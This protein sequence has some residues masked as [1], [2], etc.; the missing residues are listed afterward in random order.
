MHLATR[1]LRFFFD[2]GS[3]V[4]LWQRSEEAGAHGPYAVDHEALPLTRNTKAALTALVA[5][6]DLSIDWEDAPD[7]GPYWSQDAKGVFEHLASTAFSAAKA[8]LSM[9]G[10]ELINEHSPELSQGSSKIP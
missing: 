7:S 6:A 5:I 9:H 1:V 4:C 10:Y 2:P 3:G 8:E